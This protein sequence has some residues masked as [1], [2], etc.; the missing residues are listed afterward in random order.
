M[1]S[2]MT[3][4]VVDDDSLARMVTADSLRDELFTVIE[5]DNA[6]AALSYLHRRAREVDLLFSEVRMPG[7]IDGAGLAHH[8]AQ[9][10]P[11]IT[12]ALVSGRPRPALPAG[13]SFLLKP[14]DPASLGA[15]FRSWLSARRA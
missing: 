11:W 15:Q 14:Y 13:A 2:N 12:L 5:A 3:V 7:E 1:S 9:S 6:E 8:V 10:W 4:L